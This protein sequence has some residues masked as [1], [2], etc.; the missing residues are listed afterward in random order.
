MADTDHGM[1]S[2]YLIVTDSQS[3]SLAVARYALKNGDIALH[4]KKVICHRAP[5]PYRA[6]GA[7]EH[8]ELDRAASGDNRARFNLGDG[9]RWT[10]PR[11][12]H[13]G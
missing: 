6:H 10:L 8:L 4:F 12:L 5:N 13:D 9:C 7:D 1:N 2:R 11:R 3:I